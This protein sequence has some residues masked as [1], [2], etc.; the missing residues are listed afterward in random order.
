[1]K[2]QT[3]S[4]SYH[5]K[6]IRIFFV[7]TSLVCLSCQSIQDYNNFLV[8]SSVISEI[9]TIMG[10][11]IGG[12]TTAPLLLFS[13]PISY[14]VCCDSKRR[15]EFVSTPLK[16]GAYGGGVVFGTLFLPAALFSRRDSTK[17]FKITPEESPQK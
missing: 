10:N 11:V 15:K 13:L 6:Y 3:G 17:K 12:A 16:W 9:P 4:V 8:E 2:L 14:V 1:M 5:K 7:F